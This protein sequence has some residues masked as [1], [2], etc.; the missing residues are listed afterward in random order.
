MSTPDTVTPSFARETTATGAYDRQVSAFRRA[1]SADASTT[2]PAVAGRYHLYVSY[3]CPWAHRTI[4]ARRLK[5]LEDVIGMSVVDPIR[6]DRGWAFTGGDFVDP[7]NGYT[8]LREAYL[9]TDPQFDARVTVPVLWDTET[10]TVVNNESSEVL[11]I[12]NSGFGNLASDAVDL[13]PEALRDGID[14]VNARVY[15]TL[16]NGVYKSGFTTSQAIYEREVTTVFETLDWLESR[17]ADRRYLVTDDLP[18]EADWCAFT[19]LVRFDPV[20]PNL[21][22]YT[23]DLYQS[24]GIADTVRIDQIKRHYFITHPKIN[25]N[26]LVPLGPEIDWDEPHGRG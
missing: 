18:T 1:V 7:L 14:E 8:F 5:G 9:A 10:K 15:D 13:Y 19:T 16:N 17:L 23:R 22:A 24:Y 11:R 6:D 3:A 20:Y 12:L 25:G 2:F 26:R 4:I 21:W